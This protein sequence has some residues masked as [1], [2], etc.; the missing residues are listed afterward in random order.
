LNEFSITV[1]PSA[2]HSLGDNLGGPLLWECSCSWARY[3]FVHNNLGEESHRLLFFLC[4]AC[5]V[6]WKKRREKK[7]G[8][9]SQKVINLP[10]HDILSFGK[11]SQKS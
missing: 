7:R 9:A 4:G 1:V 2:A 8:Q 3:S 6:S 10:I 5:Q 11:T